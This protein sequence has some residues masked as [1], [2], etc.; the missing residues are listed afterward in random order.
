[1]C[2]V[3]SGCHGLVLLLLFFSKDS[4]SSS[5][6]TNNQGVESQGLKVSKSQDVEADGKVVDPS[7]T[8]S[9]MG[10]PPQKAKS[11]S[12]KTGKG[13]TSCPLHCTCLQQSFRFWRRVFTYCSV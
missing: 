2:F 6:K 10:S 5:D 1:M 13:S 9:P 12:P 7:P 8:D 4:N 3:H 11:G